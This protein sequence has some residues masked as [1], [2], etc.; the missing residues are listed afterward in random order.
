MFI[1]MVGLTIS[2]LPFLPP[3]LF[4]QNHN[5]HLAFNSRA[6]NSE[7]KFER[8][9]IEHGLPHNSVSSILQ[10][11]RGFMWF[12]TRDGFARYDGHSFK[13]FRHDPTDS[14]SLSNSWIWLIYEDRSDYLW[15]STDY[16][17]NKF[18][19][20]S[21]TFTRYLHLPDPNDSTKLSNRLI[22]PIHEDRNGHT[23]NYPLPARSCQSQQPRP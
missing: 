4:A 12:G 22:R 6:Q 2:L 21:E 5:A 20:D 16:G 7:F 15:I 11:S 17:L 18:H 14:T 9:T 10:D 3:A 19:R 1:K 23:Q 8:L 13:I